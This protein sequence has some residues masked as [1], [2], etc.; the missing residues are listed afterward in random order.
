MVALVVSPRYRV[1]NPLHHAYPHWPVPRASV[2]RCP[3]P[4]A[5]VPPGTASSV[6]VDGAVAVDAECRPVN[7]AFPARNRNR[8]A[9]LETAAA[10][11]RSVRSSLA[12]IATGFG[13]PVAAAAA[14]G[15]I[16][17]PEFVLAAPASPAP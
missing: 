17:R 1:T 4:L 8:C 12:S 11:G 6:F 5:W 15:K 7:Y 14:G 13:F 3:A 9:S 2:D 16:C 10:E